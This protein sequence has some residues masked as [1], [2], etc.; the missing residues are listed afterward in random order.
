MPGTV[1][2]AQSYLFQIIFTSLGGR[3]YYSSFKHDKQSISE[4]QR[5]METKFDSSGID[6]PPGETDWNE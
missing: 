1:Q 4:L 5:K 2:G 6:N 3:Y